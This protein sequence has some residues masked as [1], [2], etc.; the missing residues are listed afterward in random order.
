MGAG[1]NRY[2]ARHDVRPVD[3]GLRRTALHPRCAGPVLRP[4]PGGSVHYRYR[5]FV[6]ANGEQSVHHRRGSDREC[7][8]ADQRTGIC[9]KLAGALAPFVLGALL[10]ADADTL[11]ADLAALEGPLSCVRWDELAARVIMPYAVMAAAL[12]VGLCQL[13]TAAGTGP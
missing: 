2:E 5:A 7:R 11:Q 4:V 3:H 8:S 10:L 12:F 13:L 9:N 1:K 6:A